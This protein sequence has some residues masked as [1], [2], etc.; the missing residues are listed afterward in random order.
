MV[1]KHQQFPLEFHRTDYQWI[2]NFLFV[3]FFLAHRC[4]SMTYLDFQRELLPKHGTIYSFDLL[5]DINV[6]S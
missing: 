3:N 2:T 1:P 5:S 6:I 4:L